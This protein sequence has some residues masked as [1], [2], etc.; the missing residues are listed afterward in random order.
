MHSL[1]DLIEGDQTRVG[2]WVQMPCADS[3][4]ILAASGCQFAIIDLE[5]GSFDFAAVDMLVRAC[6]ANHMVSIVR[7]PD[8]HAPTVTKAL[9]CGA[10]AVMIPRV[11]TV[12]EA[13]AAIACTRWA[14][15]GTRGACPC[16]RSGEHFV[17]D[18]PRFRASREAASGAM[19][20]LETP[21]AFAAIEDICA[22]DGLRGI[23]LGPF[24]LSMAMG[25]NGD[26]RAPAVQ[27]ALERAVCAAVAR[28]VP[29]LMPLFDPDTANT[30]VQKARWQAL[31][32]RLFAVGTDKIF[33]SLAARSFFGD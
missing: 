7:V 28:Q 12:E 5:H 13:R 31:G 26:W 14:P 3:V 32:V 18:W 27:S 16:V 22:L 10:A 29:V 11:R 20:L 1:P 2:T 33:L 24:D 25:L 21:E 4:D 19:L 8:A 23:A 30:R 9:D 6:D 17:R 15:E